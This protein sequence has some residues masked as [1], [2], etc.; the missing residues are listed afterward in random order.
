LS[1]DPRVL[2]DEKNILSLKLLRKKVL[3]NLKRLRKL[4]ISD[5]FCEV[6]RKK[7]EGGIGKREEKNFCEI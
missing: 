3:P 4:N 7:K 6:H 2:V 1:K 5:D